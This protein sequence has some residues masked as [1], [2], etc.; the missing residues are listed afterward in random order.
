M[1]F[2]LYK[3]YQYVKTYHPITGQPKEDWEYIQDIQ[4]MTSTKLYTT[5]TGDVVYRKYE[6]TGITTYKSFEHDGTYKLENIS[7]AYEVASFNIDG[8][9]AQLLLKEVVL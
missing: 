4:I 5:T 9:Y 3:L 2:E 8:R 7:K 1:R 6:P